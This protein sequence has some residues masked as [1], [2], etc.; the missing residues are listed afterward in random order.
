MEIL[1]RNREK[2]IALYSKAFARVIKEYEDNQERG[3]QPFIK[4]LVFYCIKSMVSQPVSNS[5]TLEEAENDFQLAC[6]VKDLIG[7]LTPAEFMNIFPIMK[8]YKGHKWHMKDYFYTR[9][10]I[11]SLDADKPI[12]E[13][14]LEFLWEYHNR[15]ISMLNVVIMEYMSRL[16]QF[17]GQKSLAMEWAEMNGLNTYTQFTDQK[18]REY[19]VDSKSGKTRR[20]KRKPPRYLKVVK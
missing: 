2:R 5:S 16:R 20:L 9:D 1:K 10:Y 18:G 11:R 17:Q 3:I 15:E 8:E 14:S 6:I 19:L 12:G 7:L 4:R 13:N